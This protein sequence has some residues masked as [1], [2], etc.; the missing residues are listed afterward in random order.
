MNP[1]QLRNGANDAIA[2]LR[3]IVKRILSLLEREL[4]ADVDRMIEQM[5]GARRAA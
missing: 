1:E 3:S 5:A 2:F 4:L